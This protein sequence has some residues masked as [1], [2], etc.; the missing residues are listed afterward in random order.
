MKCY[1]SLS[2]GEGWA[3]YHS[4]AEFPYRV[5]KLGIP[6]LH[7]VFYWL[8]MPEKETHTRKAKL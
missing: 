4:F 8:Y 2:I 1:L 5:V 3:G 6:F 7:V